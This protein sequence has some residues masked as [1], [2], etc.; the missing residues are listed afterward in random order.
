MQKIKPHL[1]YDKEAREAAGL[2]TSVFRGKIL[3]H[4]VLTGTPSGDC[5]ILRFEILGHEFAA[6]SA[7]PYF[8]F[9]PSISFLVACSSGEEVDRYHRA[10]S[11]GGTGIKSPET[12]LIIQQQF[13]FETGKPK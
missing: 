2:Y 7:G 13:A 8:K 12:I 6:I 9:N 5:D 11:D 3:H 10:L 4:S 1:W